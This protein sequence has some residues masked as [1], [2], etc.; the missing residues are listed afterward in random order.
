MG[1]EV[2]IVTVDA[3]NVDEYGFFCYKSKPKAAGYQQNL[4]WLRQRFAEGLRIKIL[5]Q[6]RRSVGFVE[7]TPGESA[8]RAVHAPGCLV[9]HCIWVVGQAKKQGYGLRLLDA[10]LQDA[11]QS[12]AH[13]VAA[14]TTSRVWLAGSKLFLKAGFEVADRAPPCFELLVRRF[15]EAS[16]P[17]FP[18]DW[19]ERRANLGPGL[20]V[21]RSGQCPYIEDGVQGI[22]Q[23]AR[24]RGAEARIVELMSGREVQEQAP[25]PYGT[26]EVVYDG[27]LLSHHFLGRQMR[28]TLMQR[29]AG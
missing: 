9:V 16:S 27:E 8:W 29:L 15:D 6:G 21:V 23:L 20:T 7:Y 28:E 2:T 11:R 19:T 26:F 3:A 22:V 13:G 1:G 24:E 18:T 25:S 17:E 10:C 12:G 14:V 5:F 4:C